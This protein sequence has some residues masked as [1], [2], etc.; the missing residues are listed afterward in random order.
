MPRPSPAERYDGTPQGVA[1]ECPSTRRRFG[2][3]GSDEENSAVVAD[4][5]N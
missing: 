2:L 5:G 4:R 3:D 1:A